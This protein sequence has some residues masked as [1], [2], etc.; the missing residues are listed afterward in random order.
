MDGNNRGSFMCWTSTRQ[1]ERCSIWN[2]RWER[3][4]LLQT[5]APCS[6]SGV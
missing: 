6:C 2:L 1:K 3:F 4:V 5:R